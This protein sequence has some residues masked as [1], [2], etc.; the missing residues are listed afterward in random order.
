MLFKDLSF[1]DI[2]RN[3]IIIA[4]TEIPGLMALRKKFSSKRPLEDVR[5]AGSHHMTI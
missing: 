4:E 1:V 5:I 3:V 2:G